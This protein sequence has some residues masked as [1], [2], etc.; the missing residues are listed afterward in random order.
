MDFELRSKDALEYA[1]LTGKNI[2]QIKKRLSAKWWPDSVPKTR[3]VNI[4]NFFRSKTK[5]FTVKRIRELCEETGVDANFLIDV[6]PMKRIN[7]D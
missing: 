1:I 7:N 2:R 5:S 3:E 4:S 6:K